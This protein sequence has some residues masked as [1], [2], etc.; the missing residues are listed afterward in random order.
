MILDEK[1]II[2]NKKKPQTI[3]SAAFMILKIIL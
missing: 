1:I 3:T 2:L